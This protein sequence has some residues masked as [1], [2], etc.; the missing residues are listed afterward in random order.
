MYTRPDGRAMMRQR[1][2]YFSRQTQHTHDTHEEISTCL[3]VV[4][5]LHTL[6]FVSICATLLVDNVLCRFYVVDAVKCWL[7][8]R[9]CK[10]PFFVD[11]NLT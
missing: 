5:L 11:D 2:A 7:F 9:L 4:F 8:A 1:N 6:L 3:D 10:V